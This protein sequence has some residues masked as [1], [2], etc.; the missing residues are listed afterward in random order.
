MT[1]DRLVGAIIGSALYAVVDLA[2]ALLG[3]LIGRVV[4]VTLPVVVWGA[5]GVG[6]TK[7]WW[8]NDGK[9]IFLG[10]M[11]LITLVVAAACL[12]VLANRLLLRPK[13]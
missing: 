9:Q 3:F 2:F 13:F 12:G 1:L 5:W 10:S 6:L 11:I 7:G 8:G 4:V